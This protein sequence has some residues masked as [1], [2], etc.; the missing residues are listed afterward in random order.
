M[1]T[2]AIEIGFNAVLEPE[3]FAQWVCD[4]TEDRYKLVAEP[5]H[6]K[7]VNEDD[8]RLTVYYGAP[9]NAM[10]VGW[11]LPGFTQFMF[12]VIFDA[13]ASGERGEV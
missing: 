3:R 12:G 13:V 2:E 11:I 10:P 9:T 7:V 8:V 6:I 4:L 5:V 1:G